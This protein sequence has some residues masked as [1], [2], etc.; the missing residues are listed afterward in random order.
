MVVAGPLIPKAT[1]AD[2]VTGVEILTVLLVAL[3][4]GLS[5]DEV[6]VTITGPLTGSGK[7]TMFCEDVFSAREATAGNTKAPVAGL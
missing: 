2:E 7:V 1:V 6:A 5:A 4:S 3:P